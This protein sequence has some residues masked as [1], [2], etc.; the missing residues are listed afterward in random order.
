MWVKIK[1]VR[2]LQG[3]VTPGIQ[4]QKE[5]TLEAEQVSAL[6]LNICVTL[7]DFLTSYTTLIYKMEIMVRISENCGEDHYSWKLVLLSHWWFVVDSFCYNCQ[8]KS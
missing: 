4:K 1:Q 7:S 6:P 2:L 8:L 5:L 3:L